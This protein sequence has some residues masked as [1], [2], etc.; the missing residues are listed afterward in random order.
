MWTWGRNHEKQLGHD[1]ESDFNPLVCDVPKRVTTLGGGTS[2]QVKSVSASGVASFAVCENGEAFSWGSSK[3]GQLGL[4][5]GIVESETPRRIPCSF[6]IK[7]ISA[8]WGHAVGLADTPNGE[9][10]SWGYSAH[11]R[12]GYD[13]SYIQQSQEREGGASKITSTTLEDEE[14]AAACV[15]QP[16]EVARL[17]GIK[18]VGAAC[19]ADHTIAFSEWGAA[20][21]FGDNSMNQLGTSRED[22]PGLTAEMIHLSEEYTGGKLQRV[23][24][25]DSN[26]SNVIHSVLFPIPVKVESVACGYG[27]SLAIV[28]RCQDGSAL[29]SS[30]ADQGF[31]EVN[32]VYSWGWDVFQGVQVGNPAPV[33]R[34]QGSGADAVL[35]P[36]R[37]AAGRVHSVALTASGEVYT[38]G[39]SKNGRLGLDSFPNDAMVPQKVHLPEDLEV[40]R[41]VDVVAGYDHTLLLVE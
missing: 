34:F 40:K 25:L 20:F 24:S 22:Q 41:V 36:I 14:T 9:F 11:G 39:S 37:V 32:C 19:G 12:L 18:I 30:A 3:R 15:W 6:P 7:S 28:K 21:A 1:G 29:T 4:G 13:H 35:D 27:H 31:G 16:K 10:L 23:D 17:S 38:W 26:A 33:Q 2:S 5:A 8:G